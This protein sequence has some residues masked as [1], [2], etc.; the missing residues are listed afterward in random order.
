MLLHRNVDWKGREE[1]EEEE[2]LRTVESL[3]SVCYSDMGRG[4]EDADYSGF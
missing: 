3:G 2:G 1:E 4:G